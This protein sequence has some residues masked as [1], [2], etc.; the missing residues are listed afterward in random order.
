MSTTAV[1]KYANRCSIGPGNPVLFSNEAGNQDSTP[2]STMQNHAPARMRGTGTWL[3]TVLVVR[4]SSAT[5]LLLNFDRGSAEV[6]Q[7]LLQLPKQVCPGWPTD[8][9]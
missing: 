6:S 2:R 3:R 8:V 9:G 1:Q 5:A 4:T 7:N